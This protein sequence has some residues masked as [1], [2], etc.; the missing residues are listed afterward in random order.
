MW[1]RRTRYTTNTMSLPR[2]LVGGSGCLLQR[3][4]QPAM[5]LALPLHAGETGSPSPLLIRL[6]CQ[7]PELALSSRQ[8]CLPIQPPTA[9]VSQASTL[10]AKCSTP[11]FIRHRLPK[12]TPRPLPSTFKSDARDDAPRCSCTPLDTERRK[13][14]Q[15]IRPPA[16]PS[17][18]L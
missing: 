10:L 4:P 2:T 15:Y 9:A 17:H 13:V 6:L 3:K 1:P 12:N 7:S 8:L 16:V 5:I 11:M 14:C 18:V